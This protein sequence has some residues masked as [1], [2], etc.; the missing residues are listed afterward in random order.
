MPQTFF[1][2]DQSEHLPGQDSFVSDAELQSASGFIVNA[3]EDTFH[4]IP[5]RGD[6]T[7]SKPRTLHDVPVNEYQKIGDTSTWWSVR[8]P[9]GV[10]ASGIT[11]AVV[12]FVTASGAPGDTV[13]FEVSAK[14]IAVSGVGQNIATE[15]VLTASISANAHVPPNVIQAAQITV[16][17]DPPAAFFALKFT[18]KGSADTFEESI[19]TVAHGVRFEVRPE[20]T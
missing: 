9:F 2:I 11:L 13:D 1:D 19:F 20:V 8:Q 5:A 17:V 15:P 14:R 6:E 7:D 16:P 12:W 10:S 4:L 3:I 18:R